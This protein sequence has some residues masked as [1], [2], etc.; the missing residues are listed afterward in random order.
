M[1]GLGVEGESFANRKAGI[2]AQRGKWAGLSTALSGSADST[3]AVG[4][5]QEPQERGQ[6]RDGAHSL[7]QLLSSLTH[8]V[9]PVKGCAPFVT[10]LCHG[11]VFYYLP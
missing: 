4:T 11:T 7:R 5:E 2:E 8:Q 3:K 10:G 9:H 6:G 1:S